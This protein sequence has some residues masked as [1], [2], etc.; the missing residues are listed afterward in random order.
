MSV[1]CVDQLFPTPEIR[2]FLECGWYTQHHFIEENWFCYVFQITPWLGMGLCKTS[3]SALMGLLGLK[4]CMMSESPSVHM[5]ST[6]FY[7]EMISLKSYTNSGPY[8]LSP[9]LHRLLSVAGK[10]FIRTFP[11]GLSITDSPSSAHHSIVGIFAN[12]YVL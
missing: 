5:W 12:Y 4:L 3:L 1:T 2:P 8:N 7:L 6:L 10:K 11:S 9:I